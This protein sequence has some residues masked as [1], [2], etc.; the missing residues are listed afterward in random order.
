MPR[1]RHIYMT[2]LI[3]NVDVQF[4]LGLIAPLFTVSFHD[5]FEKKMFSKIFK[6]WQV[7]DWL[8]KWIIMLW[9][10]D[11]RCP[12]V[13]RHSNVGLVWYLIQSKSIVITGK[14]KQLLQCVS[15]SVAIMLKSGNQLKLIDDKI[16]KW[17]TLCK[18]KELRHKYNLCI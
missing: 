18:H 1:T 15:L 4:N 11:L 2:L 7:C 16:N 10:M 3:I 5:M 17:Y 9:F 12:R 13:F 8:A 6:N 14:L